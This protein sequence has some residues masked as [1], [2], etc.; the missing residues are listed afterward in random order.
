MYNPGENIHF[1]IDS[2]LSFICNVTNNYRNYSNTNQTII[3]LSQTGN[4]ITAA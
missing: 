3:E 2:G 4:F 1:Q